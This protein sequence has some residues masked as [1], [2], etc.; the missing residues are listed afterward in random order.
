MSSAPVPFW[1]AFADRLEPARG[2]PETMTQSIGI[3]LIGAS[4]VASYAV[5]EPAQQIP[6]VRV[7]AVAARDAARA[8]DYAAQFGIERVH[9]T[10]NDLICDPEVDLVYLGTPPAAH[11]AQAL[12]SIAAGKSLLVEKPFALTAEEARTVHAAAAA[13]GVRVFEAMHSVHHALFERVLEIVRNGEIG[14]VQ[15]IDSSFDAQIRPDDP[16][17]WSRALGGGALMDLGVYPLAWVRRL[18]GEQFTVATCDAEFRDGVDAR[19]EAQLEFPAG[20]KCVVAASMTDPFAAR[21]I[22]QGDAGLLDVDNPLSPQKGHSLVVRSATGERI[23][24]FADAPGTYRAQLEAV[25]ATL[26]QGAPFPLPEDDYVR[27]MEAIERIRAAMPSG[28]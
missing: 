12:A 16:I 6:G 9:R 22:V 5:I 17:R 27:S 23:E 8:R 19:F 18:L 10:Y 13:A 11:A 26:E 20:I 4:R 14:S 2:E 3:G 25:A 1:S 7:V 28:R 15:E 24:T 21:L